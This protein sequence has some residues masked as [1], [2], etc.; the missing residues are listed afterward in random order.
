MVTVN[1]VVLTSGGK[2]SV[3]AI[4]KRLEELMPPD[5]ERVTL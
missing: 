3:P 4:R 1:G 5:G 2:I